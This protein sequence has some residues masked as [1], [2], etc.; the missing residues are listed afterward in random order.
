GITRS[1]IT[2]VYLKGSTDEAA[3]LIIDLR[4]NHKIF[5]S[6]VTYPVVERGELML[7]MIPT[8]AHTPEDVEYTLNAFEEVRAKM[9]KGVYKTGEAIS[10][11]VG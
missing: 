6:V 9:E 8:A 5:V 2:P 11:N 3:R 1:P 10:M 4:E 7:R